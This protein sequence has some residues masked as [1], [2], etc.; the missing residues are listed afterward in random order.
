MAC[1]VIFSP[2]LIGTLLLVGVL[3]ACKLPVFCC[4]RLRAVAYLPAVGLCYYGAAVG[5]AAMCFGLAW[6]KVTLLAAFALVGGGWLL[7]DPVSFLF[8]PARR[9]AVAR[10]VEFVEGQDGPRGIYEMVRVIG[11]E[12]GRRLVSVAVESG[13]IPAGR[14][15]LAVGEDGGVEELEFDY[16]AAAHGVRPWF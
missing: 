1:A 13:C 5:L 8:S 6:W 2:L 11:T 14:R 3:I 10:A 4:E 12:P 16:V 7:P 15:F 9:R